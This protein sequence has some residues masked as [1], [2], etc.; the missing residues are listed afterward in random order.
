MDF[1]RKCP[2][3]KSLLPH[4]NY[5]IYPKKRRSKEWLSQPKSLGY[6]TIAMWDPEIYP[7]F[8]VFALEGNLEVVWL[9]LL[10][11]NKEWLIFIVVFYWWIFSSNFLLFSSPEDFSLTYWLLIELRSTIL[12]NFLVSSWLIGIHVKRISYIYHVK[13]FPLIYWKYLFDIS[14]SIAIGCCCCN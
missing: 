5:W 2:R 9:D 8:M 3:F 4:Y 11:E 10:G 14:I 6:Q 1:Q 13:I 12:S 7:P